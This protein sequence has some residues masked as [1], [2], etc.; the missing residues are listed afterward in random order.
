M[1]GKKPHQ[2]WPFGVGQLGGCSIG[3]LQAFK[4]LKECNV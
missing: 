3:F 4:F 2:T 1:D